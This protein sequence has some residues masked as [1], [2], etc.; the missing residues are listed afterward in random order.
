M[1]REQSFAF[2]KMLPNAFHFEENK[3]P[4]SNFIKPSGLEKCEK[5]SYFNCGD[6]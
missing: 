3:M 4:S 6:I 2:C 5:R 1:K